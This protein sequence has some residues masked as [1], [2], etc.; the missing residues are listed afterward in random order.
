MLNFLEFR[1][2][3]AEDNPRI[4]QLEDQIKD[5]LSKISDIKKDAKAGKTGNEA[6]IAS[7]TAQSKA[8]NDIST[9]MKNLATEIGR[10]GASKEAT[11]NIY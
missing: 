9:M 6:K 11:T 7:L 1:I 5:K 2:L 10:A 4:S 3:E 8:Y